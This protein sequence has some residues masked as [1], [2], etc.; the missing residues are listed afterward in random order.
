[1]NK[2]LGKELQ[3]LR[4]DDLAQLLRARTLRNGL[5]RRAHETFKPLLCALHA[6]LQSR[7]GAKMRGIL[8]D[9]LPSSASSHSTSRKSSAT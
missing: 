1:M 5:D 4:L 7:V 9:R 8:A 3:R 2:L 6:N